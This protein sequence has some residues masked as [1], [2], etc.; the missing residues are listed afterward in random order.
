[1]AIIFSVLGA[2]W[3]SSIG[4]TVL[5]GG[6]LFLWG[7]WKGWALAAAGRDAAVQRAMASRDVYWQQVIS[8]ANKDHEDEMREAIKV[9][10]SVTVVRSSAEL[11][12][13]CTDPAT[14]ANCR[15]QALYRMPSIQDHHMEHK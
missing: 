13:L 11:I 5:I 2:V 14:N 3:S 7:V 10:K 8:Q 1:M 6:G 4:R 9:A 12:L 15:D